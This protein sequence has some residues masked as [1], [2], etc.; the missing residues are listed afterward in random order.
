MIF[1]EFWERYDSWY[2]RHKDLFRKELEFIIRNLDD[3]ELGLEIGVGSGRF[4]KELG[5]D[6]GIDISKQLLKLAKKRGVE[7]LRCDANYLP[8]KRVFDA[9]FFIFTLSFLKNPVLA[10]KSAKSVLVKEG[11]IIVCEI[12]KESELAEECL[13]KDSPFYRFARFYTSDEI[14]KMLENT[15][16]EIVK[17]EFEDLK[18]GRDIILVVGILT[19]S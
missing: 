5:I 13:K 19:E 2:D 18:Y 15:G 14:L 7:V 11:R 17:T 9:V 4:A 16:F 12:P 1:D 10:L 3:F 6:Y 8:F